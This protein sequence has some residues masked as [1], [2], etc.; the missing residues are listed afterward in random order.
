MVM[1]FVLTRFTTLNMTIAN[2]LAVFTS[3]LFAYVVNKLFVFE[4]KTD[5]L[6]ALGKEAASFIGMRLGTMVVDVGGVDLFHYLGMND[7]I[8][9]FLLQFIILVLNYLISKFFV[10]RKK[11]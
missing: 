3:I 1:Y 8:A 4:H 11:A 5:S 7:L 9:K 2:A 10:F 6:S